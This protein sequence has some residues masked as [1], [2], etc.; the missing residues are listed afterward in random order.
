MSAVTLSSRGARGPCQCRVRQQQSHPRV[1]VRA[2]RSALGPLA[3]SRGARNSAPW[4][5]NDAIVQVATASGESEE[6][7]WSRRNDTADIARQQGVTRSRLQHIL[8]SPYDTEIFAVLVPALLA[9]L[10]DP[11]MV[12]IDTGNDSSPDQHRHCAV[13]PHLTLQCHCSYCW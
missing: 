13:D 4:R 9:I 3:A 11:V 6:N 12:L 8:N 10:L 1:A 7:S 5:N 2:R